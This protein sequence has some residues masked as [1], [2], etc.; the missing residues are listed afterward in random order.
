[1][2]VGEQQ[3]LLEAGVGELVAAGVGDAVDEPVGAES[4]QVVG[5]FS[6]GDV[7][8]GGGWN[9]WVTPA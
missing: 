7:L 3:C 2:G 8:G 4:S 6:G 9:Y 1:M 5:Y